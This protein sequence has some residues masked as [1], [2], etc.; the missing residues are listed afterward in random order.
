M[1]GERSQAWGNSK[2]DQGQHKDLGSS[3][4]DKEWLEGAR[5]K[6]WFGEESKEHCPGSGQG[7]GTH[8]AFLTASSI[9]LGEAPA[10]SRTQ[11]VPGSHETAGGDVQ[12]PFPQ[13]SCVGGGEAT[14]S[15]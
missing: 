1:L 13:L 3:Q 5:N 11:T 15:F 4:R 2:R 8:C 7:P 14:G 9:D 10:L 12:V 6:P